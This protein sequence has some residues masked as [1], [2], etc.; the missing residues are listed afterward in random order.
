MLEG[1]DRFVAQEQIHGGRRPEKFGRNLWKPWKKGAV[2]VEFLC[3]FLVVKF[4]LF[5]VFS[6]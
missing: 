6:I 3:F 5:D 1:I 4:V 2:L